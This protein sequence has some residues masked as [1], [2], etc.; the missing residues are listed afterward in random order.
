MSHDFLKCLTYVFASATYTILTIPLSI[1]FFK[2]V[3]CNVNPDLKL[4][5]LLLKVSKY[6]FAVNWILMSSYNMKLVALMKVLK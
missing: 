5:L 6:S 3:F 4:A 1:N 2:K